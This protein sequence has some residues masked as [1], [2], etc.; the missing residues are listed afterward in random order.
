[1]VHTDRPAGR[2]R[3]HQANEGLP[4]SLESMTVSDLAAAISQRR[5]DA[6]E[7]GE[8]EA[9]DDPP[10]YGAPAIVDGLI[11]A[12]GGGRG[13]RTGKSG[14][15]GDPQ[16]ELPP[17]AVAVQG[18]ASIAARRMRRGFVH[19]MPWLGGR[20]RWTCGEKNHSARDCPDKPKAVGDRHSSRRYKV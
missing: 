12:L 1:M 4:S 8:L 6:E 18:V 15:N 20:A 13:P 9:S 16:P 17:T 10:A 3:L 2:G 19:T 14:S 5:A 11:A 7:L